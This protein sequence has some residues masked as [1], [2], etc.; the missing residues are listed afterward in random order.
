MLVATSLASCSGDS[1]GTRNPQVSSTT[2][3]G[4]PRLQT[5]SGNPWP[6]ASKVDDAPGLAKARKNEYVGAPVELFD[7]ASGESPVEAKAVRHAEFVASARILGGRVRHRQHQERPEDRAPR[8][9]RESH[10]AH[11]SCG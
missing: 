3:A 1:A 2:L 8:P 9:A 4:P 7:L 10:L 5:I 6:I 11:L